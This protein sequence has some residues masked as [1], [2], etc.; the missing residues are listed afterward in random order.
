MGSVRGMVFAA[1]VQPPVFRF[2]TVDE[3]RLRY[4]D[5][6]AGTPV[7]LLHGNGS[8]I[9]DF[10]SSGI[11][12]APGYRF[13][14]FDR[15]GFGYSE[16]PSHRSWGA[17]EQAS[18]LL[19]ALA[20]LGIE[21]PT[22]VGH[23]WGALVALAMGLQAPEDVAGLV[24][25]SGYYY[26]IPRADIAVPASAFPFTGAVLRHAVVPF[27]RRLMAPNTVRRVFAPCEVPDRFKRAYP[28]PLAMRTSQMRAVDEEAAMLFD[29]ARAFCRLYAKVSVPVSLIA[30]SGDLIVNTEE[31]SARLH[32]ELGTSTFHRV[33]GC[34]HM[35]H[36]A[37]PEDVV[38]AIAAVSRARRG[39]PAGRPPA[40]DTKPPSRHWLQIGE[41]LAAA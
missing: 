28:M 1:E 40:A 8:M 24:L 20:Q 6:G 16:R 35:V 2:V 13:I 10:I 29:T 25:M 22:V 34:G 5:S 18:L 39:K 27:V 4:L 41:S 32:R 9:E 14:A 23:S 36:H 11:M 26:P 30:G 31:H 19:R 38:A 37:A 3:T 21:H 12:D 7:V 33:A 15:P 17:A